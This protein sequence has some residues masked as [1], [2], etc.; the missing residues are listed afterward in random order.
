MCVSSKRIAALE[1]LQF[2]LGEGPCQE[3]FR[4]G[5]PIHTPRLDISVSA[6]WP[7]FV[8]LAEASGIGAVF[9]Y[10]LI[11]AGFKIGV[12]SLYQAHY[13]E[14]SATQHAD[15]VALTEVLTETV[16]SLQDA[17]PPG[18][19]A[20]DLEAVVTYRAETYQ[21][22]GMVAIQL[23][24]SVSEALLR[25]RAYAFAMS[26]SVDEVAGD[27]VARRLRLADDRDNH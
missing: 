16:L 21:A 18:V 7:S 27:I 22:S 11:A 26:R 13:G 14:L 19:L 20:A 10:P 23:Q 2:T 1:D 3:A 15:S 6:R 12:L 17:A 5:V 24:I 25:V 4:S 8:G 9:A